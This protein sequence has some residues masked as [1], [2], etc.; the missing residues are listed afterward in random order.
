MGNRARRLLRV[1]TLS[2]FALASAACGATACFAQQFDPSLYSGLH[3]RMIGPFR[4]GRSNGVSGVPGQPNT[5]YFGSVGGGVW[6]TE[7]SGRT[8]TPVFDAEPVGSIGAI[9]V[10][11][12]NGNVVY[13][14]TGEADMRSQIS[15]GN[16]MYK[17]TDAGKTWMHIGLDNTRQIGRVIV[18]PQNPDVVFVAALGHVYGANPDRGV[19]RST[20]GG[21]S[22]QKVLYKGD[23]VGAI[24]LA[25]DPQN[26]RTIYA[27]L[28]NTRRPPWSIYPPSYGPGGGIFKSTDGGDTWQP[29][30]NGL[31]AERVGRIGIAVAPTNAKLVYAIVDAKEG[32]LY[33]SDDAGASW[34]K[35]SDEQ[36][37]W[38]RGW[39]FCNVVVDPKDAET[40]YVSNTSVY[41]SKDGGK[42]WTA[43]KGAPGGDDYHQL[44]IYPDD[45]KRMILASD[46]GTVVT[47]DGAATWSSWYN[48]PTAELYHVS[49]DFRFPSW[50]SGAQ[51]DSGAIGV[52]TR[53]SHNEIGMQDW[54]A[55]CAGGE[56]GYTAPDPLHP[57][58]LFGGTVE[59]CNLI[60]GEVR[61]VSPEL[62]R[63]GPFRRTW[64]LPLVFSEADPHALYFS[65][66]YLFKTVD[67]GNSWTQISADMTREDPGVPPNLDDATAADAPKGKRRG[68]IYTIAPSPI[69]SHAA[70]IWI[71]TDDGYI[72]LTTDAG[73][74][75]ENVT[76]PELTPW[77]KVVMIQASHFDPQE[78]FAAVDRHRLEDNEPHIYR[79]RDEGKTW[80]TIT[81]GLPAGVYLQTIREDPVRKGLLFAG[82]ELG[83][84]V[85][86]ND[87]DKWQSLQLNLPAVSMRDLA[88]HGDDLIVGTHGRSIWVLDDISALRQVADAA[89]KADAYL[90]K[91]AEA[92]RMHAGNA[93]GSPQPRDEALAENPPAGAMIDYYL[94]ADAA[95]RLKLEIL[96]ASGKIVRSY[97]SADEVKPVDPSKLDIPPS[98]ISAPK[99]LSSAAGM[100]R[101]IW[102]LHYAA[103]AG[104]RT[105]VFA[106]FF[107]PGGVMA[108]PGSY[109]VRLTVNGK[110]MSQPLIVKMDPRIKSTSAELRKQFETAT[111][112][113][114]K[115]KQIS[116]ARE[117]VKQLRAQIAK[118]KANASATGGI[119]AA[120]DSLDRKAEEIDGP[121]SSAGANMF[122]EEPQEGATFAI[123]SGR[124]GQIESAVNAGD[125]APTSEAMKALAGAESTLAATMAKWKAL[126]AKDLPPIN[127]ELKLAGIDSIAI[128]AAR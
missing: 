77:S 20:D 83:V 88:I 122:D 56:S 120:L 49:P 115:Q 40:I 67:G 75:W 128:E 12:S 73:Q 8:W 10:A 43:V 113:A 114:Q 86:F 36:R 89:A 60:T 84:F 71:G 100:H 18:D 48:Q 51:Q 127:A 5:F 41:R 101:W 123:L 103:A 1:L 38:G 106:M 119:A 27:A 3:W 109:T 102:D 13:V 87:G 52:P 82:T 11:P 37:I 2:L 29:L 50:A 125:G 26:S 4:G 98:W 34:K 62:G 76:P 16:G 54:E 91:P 80:Q 32:G 44:W 105:G 17:S 14:G 121:S 58:I 7:N 24:D 28:W 107:G 23:S 65:D 47:E 35:M 96:D 57:E 64:T 31:P 94:K 93:N 22:W 55:V 21:T 42:T 108:L 104:G 124:F 116:E 33:R 126:T 61:N 15:F 53:S 110:S 68:V 45:P 46:Q 72:H 9:A 99:Q 74:N 111:A 90:F 95:G 63:K 97:S 69:A 78:A 70:I 19:F 66:Q 79:T 85:S 6:K 112:I 39:Y 92:I 30:T 59:R 118:R 81:N 25:F 117:A